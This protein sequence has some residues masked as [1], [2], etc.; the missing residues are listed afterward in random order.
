MKQLKIFSIA[1]IAIIA[2]ASCSTTKVATK[3][4]ENV[5]IVKKTK[6]SLIPQ[7]FTSLYNDKD[8][9]NW[10]LTD[11]FE[12]YQPGMSVEKAYNTV[13]KDLPAQTVIVAVVDAGMDINH[14]DLKDVIWTNTDE[15]PDNG[16]DDDHNGYIDDVHGWNFLGSKDGKMVTNEQLEL[17]RIV[18]KY[19]N[20]WQG[21]ERK[22]IEP[23]DT[24]M[25]D[26]Y[27][28]AEKELASRIEQI[29]PLE[30]RLTGL[31]MMAQ[32][33]FKTLKDFLKTDKLTEEAVAKIDTDD[34]NVNQ[35]KAMYL[36]G[37]TPDYI[38]RFTH[39]VEGQLKY[40]LNVD[41]HAR[42]Q[43][44]DPDNYNDR[45]YGNPNVIPPNEQELHAT[46]VGGI[47]AAVRN[48]GKG[49][50]GVA[51]HVLLMPVRAVP[52]GD[53]YDKDI[54]LAFRY[55]VDN[56]AKVINTS[57]G[58]YYSPHKDWVWDAIKYAADHDVLIV[59]GV[60]NEGKNM[61]NYGDDMSYPNDGDKPG[62][63]FVD[64]FLNVGAIGP[65]Y[66]ADMIAPFSNYGKK[67]VDIFSPGMKIY[68]TV[69]FNKYM[70]L[71]G[72]SMASPDVAGIAALIRSRFPD[73][74]ASEVKHIIMD[75]G[76]S[77]QIE[78]ILPQ[79]DDYDGPPK[80][81]KFPNLSK[82]GKMANAYNAITMAKKMSEDKK[83]TKT[84]N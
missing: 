45:D 5:Q 58:K 23:K 72:T 15:I 82:S 26:L 27:Q 50:N 10:Q 41:F 43:G 84:N 39:Y 44:D 28:R 47:I 32:P 38:E 56:G 29:K 46:H 12:S 19:R 20:Q 62:V 59:N 69:P 18:A 25:F 7:Q 63:E 42:I 14:E 74:S 57:F 83:K 48:N 79:E 11:P 40:N 75:S 24:F 49:G 36:R 37:L 54:A 31:K 65:N 33:L 9:Q 30:K 73:L 34:E 77:P 8:L 61:D 67:T 21:K 55:A 3:K 35:A 78:V 22:D 17:T 2:L 71:Q 52:D 53:E 51:D 60:G 66:G 4:Q 80:L 81:D 6:Y 70:H 64:N 1:F 16:I 68:A 13:L 76:L